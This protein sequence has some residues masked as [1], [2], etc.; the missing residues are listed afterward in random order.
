M[1]LVEITDEDIADVQA[2]LEENFPHRR[3]GAEIVA[4][5]TAKAFVMGCNP[6]G[7]EVL[8]SVIPPSEYAKFTDVPRHRL[9]Q[10]RELQRYGFM[11][12]V[13]RAARSLE[14]RD[15]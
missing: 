13:E 1:C 10:R 14:G 6:G 2:D 4:A 3:P 11:T 15:A 12:A 7:G 9:L 5:A 8:S